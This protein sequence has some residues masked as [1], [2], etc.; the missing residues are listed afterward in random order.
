MR[1][2]QLF[3]VISFNDNW[4]AAPILNTDLSHFPKNGKIILLEQ[5]WTKLRWTISFP[6]TTDIESIE[7][8]Q[9]SEL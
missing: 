9:K 1:T 6:L 5:S 7:V 4:E 3:A 8:G 2:L